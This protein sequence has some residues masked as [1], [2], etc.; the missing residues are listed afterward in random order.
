MVIEFEKLEDH[1][2]CFLT[3]SVHKLR[4][5]DESCIFKDLTN[6]RYFLPNFIKFL[7]KFSTVARDFA[8]SVKFVSK[9]CNFYKKTYQPETGNSV[10]VLFGGF[11]TLFFS[12]ERIKKK[13]LK[14]NC[15]KG[16]HYVFLFRKRKLWQKDTLDKWSELWCLTKREWIFIC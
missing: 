5:F 4:F 12:A 15:Q 16:F 8:K 11:R 14:V 3:G 13:R 9:I 7:P 1:V 2:H 10:N 6:I